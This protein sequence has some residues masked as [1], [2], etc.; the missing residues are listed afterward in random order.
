RQYPKP[1]PYTYALSSPPTTVM[2]Q[3]LATIAP[4]T[5]H[6]RLVIADDYGVY[7]AVDKGDGT[8][9][10][11]VG[12]LDSVNSQGGNTPLINGTRNGNLQWTQCYLGTTQTSLI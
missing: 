3:V 12:Q 10:A 2:H 8:L 1:N 9:V 11:S 4:L 6:T 5:R 7:T